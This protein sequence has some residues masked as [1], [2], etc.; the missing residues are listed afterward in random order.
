M[1]VGRSA[2]DLSALIIPREVCNLTYF[3]HEG[4]HPCDWHDSR[5]GEIAMNYSDYDLNGTVVAILATN[6]F[7]ESELLEPQAALEEAG[8]EVHIVSL[9]DEDIEPAEGGELGDP[10]EVDFTLSEVTIADYDLLV[11]PGGVENPDTLRND[12]DAV[13]FV[14]A[15]SEEGKPIAAICHGPWLLIEAGIAKGRRLTSYPSI[16][17]DLEN[18][19][20]T[21]VDQEVVSHHGIITSRS[22]EDLDAFCKAIVLELSEGLSSQD[23]A[24]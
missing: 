8:A 21:W 17:T 18:A 1:V 14:R 9:D 16:K 5:E 20:A 7:E 19:G 13:D 3:L 24:A 10:V 15:F 23:L 22:P 11:L 6:G 12:E 4:V 2:R